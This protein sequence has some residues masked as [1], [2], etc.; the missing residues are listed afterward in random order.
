MLK[1]RLIGLKKKKNTKTSSIKLSVNLSDRTLIFYKE[2]T[3]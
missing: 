2:L 1:M 3:E